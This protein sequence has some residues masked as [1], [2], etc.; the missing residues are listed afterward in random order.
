MGLGGG[1]ESGTGRKDK[2]QR[3]LVG[4]CGG[5]DR[6]QFVACAVLILREER[7]MLIGG[8]E[9]GRYSK[10]T[11]A[12]LAI[13]FGL[14]GSLKEFIRQVENIRGNNDNL[15]ATLALT[16]EEVENIYNE[17]RVELLGLLRADV[18]FSDMSRDPDKNCA[19]LEKKGRDMA[20]SS[21]SKNIV[22]KTAAS[23]DLEKI[24][25]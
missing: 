14:N 19:T 16:K 24:G 9:V 21:V 20:C 11:R 18:I 1:D 23:N 5:K 3:R 12:A 4:E 13:A 6:R 22:T 8:I 10:I 17:I 2:K 25:I 15:D 7:G